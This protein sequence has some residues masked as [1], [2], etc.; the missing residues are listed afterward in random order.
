[1]AQELEVQI[2]DNLEDG[3][4]EITPFKYSILSYGADYTVD[5]LVKR[6][7]DGNIVIPS[8]QR[9]Y[10]WSFKDASRFIESLLLGL[11][12]PGIFLSKE[13]ETQKLLV[14]DGQQRLRTL[15]YFYDGTFEPTNKVFALSSVQPRFEGA[16]YKSLSEEDRRR[17]DDS[18]LHATVVKQDTPSED[19]SSIY[20]IFERLNTGG[21]QLKPQE[22]RTCIYHGEFND[23]LK[24]LNES[25]SWRLIYGAVNKNMRDQ[26]LILRF[27]AL[28]F[29]ADGYKPPMKQFLN[30]YMGRNRHL[31]LQSREQL[32][33][34]FLHAIDA[35]YN[36]LE[37]KAFKPKRALNAAVFDAV[38]V[39]IARRLDQGEIRNCNTVRERYESLLNDPAFIRSTETGTSSEDSVNTRIRLA[40]EALTNVE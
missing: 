11:P 23:V 4:D 28:Y 14:I 31:K 5:S 26:E 29:N 32:S 15:G 17:L 39:G 34:V 35:A 22:I 10:V 1:M 30:Q 19:E 16:K 36:F 20:Y 3:A 27:L 37:A 25:K 40:T 9:G 6:L 33:Y 13:Q 24:Q 18:I 38:M 7:K 8:F 12:V 2:E 21:V